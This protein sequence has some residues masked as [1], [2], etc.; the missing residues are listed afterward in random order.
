MIDGYPVLTVGYSDEL[1][2]NAHPITRFAD[3]RSGGDLDSR[4]AA[5]AAT[6]VEIVFA[7]DGAGMTPG[8]A[9]PGVRPVLYHPPQ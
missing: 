8:C 6:N 5:A 2:L 4:R 9:A 1:V 7:D 3:G